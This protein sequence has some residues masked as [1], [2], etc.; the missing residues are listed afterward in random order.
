[1]KYDSLLVPNAGVS[2]EIKKKSGVC[3]TAVAFGAKIARELS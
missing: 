3:E 1:M 2:G